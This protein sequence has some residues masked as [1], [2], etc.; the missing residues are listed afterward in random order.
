MHR[1]L[2]IWSRWAGIPWA[3]ATI[4][5]VL[6]AGILYVSTGTAAGE[7]KAP[8]TTATDISLG[9]AGAKV[10]MV[11]YS[12]FQCQYCAQ[13]ASLLS[14]LREKYKD[15][16]LFVFRFFPLENHPFGMVSAQ[17]AYAAY[18]QGKFWEMH[19]LL[20]TNQ[21]DWSTAAAPETYF[22]AY[23]SALGLDLEKFRTDYAAQTTQDYIL[24]EKAGGKQ[25]G[26]E[27]TPWFIVNGTIV[28][29]RTTAEFESLWQVGS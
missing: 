14:P 4:V 15:R 5:L 25:A 6:A 19:D 1:T 9:P 2:N 10:V 24:G 13:Y 21:Q 28:T 7:S 22:E 12:D 29:P 20:F 27:H 23:A 18:L 16:V 26:V 3:A 11:E 17:A 8:A